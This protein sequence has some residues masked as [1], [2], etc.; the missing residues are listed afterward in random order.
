MRHQAHLMKFNVQPT[1]RFYALDF[2]F[3]N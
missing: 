1:E 2:L 3:I